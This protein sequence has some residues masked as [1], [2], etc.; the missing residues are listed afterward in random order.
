MFK[1]K[2]CEANGT[3]TLRKK[4]WYCNICF[5]NN[6][7]HKFRSILGKNKILSTNEK[8]LLCLSGGTA[9]TVL[10]DMVHCGI[11]LNSHKKLRIVPHALHVIGPGNE[12]YNLKVANSIIKA[13]KHYSIDLHIINIADY[14]QNHNNLTQNVNVIPERNSVSSDMFF[15]IL[16]SMPSTARND[17][18]LKVK[19][20]LYVKCAKEISCKF[21]FTAE[22]T[23]TL[24]INLLSNLTVGR[25]SQ[26]HNDVGFC[27]KRDNEVT[28]LRP[29]KDISKEE[30]NQYITIKQIGPVHDCDML[31]NSL[32]SVIRTF[33]TDLQNN[34]QSTVSSVCKTADKI[35]IYEDKKIEHRCMLCES[36]LKKKESKISAL[37]ATN[38]SRLVSSTNSEDK[39]K[40]HDNTQI[41]R[42]SLSMF[43][44]I[45]QYLCYGC[46][47]IYSEMPINELP[48]CVKVLFKTTF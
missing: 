47:R 41:E 28:I 31:D 25:G 20:N 13:C 15:Q 6:I 30:L 11:S 22:T 3:I 44:Y 48:N 39:N 7:H 43:P 17:F 12:E 29:M 27:D 35:G 10:L 5:L 14:V 36:I 45:D 21:I 9:S 2:K 42:T 46:S 24:A 34:F 38:Y 18:I 19:Q 40:F 33:V 37:E 26:V 23:S 4:D 1:C 16:N 8:I 32:Q